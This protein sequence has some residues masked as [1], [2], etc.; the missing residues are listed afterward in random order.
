MEEKE[1]DAVEVGPKAD[2]A[3]APQDQAKESLINFPF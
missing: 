2:A 1:K 3:E